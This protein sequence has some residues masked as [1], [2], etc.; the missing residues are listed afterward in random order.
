MAGPGGVDGK[1]LTAIVFIGITRLMT[2]HCQAICHRLA[3]LLVRVS[4][5][6]NYD[7]R[8]TQNVYCFYYLVVR[9]NILPPLVTL[10][11]LFMGTLQFP[12]IPVSV[13]LSDDFLSV[14]PYAQVA[15]NQ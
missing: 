2:I 15:S 4:T 13:F 10:H 6:D 14:L 5:G 8:L 1:E 12:H 9:L 3:D 7:T 11:S